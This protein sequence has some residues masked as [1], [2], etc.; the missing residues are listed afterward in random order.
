[1]LGVFAGIE[2]LEAELAGIARARDHDARH[3]RH[4][5]VGEAVIGQCRGR[6]IGLGEF[7]QDV[8]RGGALHREEGEAGAEVGHHGVHAQAMLAEPGH[9]AV[10]PR[11]RGG[12]LEV[13]RRM[14]IAREVIDH[15]A[16]GLHQRGIEHLAVVDPRDIVHQGLA[17]QLH[18]I[19][20]ALPIFRAAGSGLP[21]ASPRVPAVISHQYDIVP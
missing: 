14:A 15:A 17:Q 10:D 12:E 2:Q 21:T 7:S 8:A 5:G 18:G 20:A 4:G 13:R 19:A 3:L 9:H 6:E 16:V 1:M 11:G